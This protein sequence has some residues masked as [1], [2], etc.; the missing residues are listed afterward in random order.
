[1]KGRD[2]RRAL[3]SLITNLNAI[4]TQVNNGLKDEEGKQFFKRLNTNLKRADQIDKETLKQFLQ[5]E[6]IRAHIF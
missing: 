4:S 3:F 5:E 1:M 2:N 6:G